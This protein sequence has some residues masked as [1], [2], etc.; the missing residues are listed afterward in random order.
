[1]DALVNVCNVCSLS[2]ELDLEVLNLEVYCGSNHNYV[3]S[4]SAYVLSVNM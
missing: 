4:N 2:T 3:A 1:M